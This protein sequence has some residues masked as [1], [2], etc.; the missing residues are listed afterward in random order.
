MLSEV[1]SWARELG[2]LVTTVVADGVLVH[3]EGYLGR[4][5]DAVHSEAMNAHCGIAARLRWNVII[6]HLGR[7]HGLVD[8][9]HQVL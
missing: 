2:G 7:G 3:L 8:L 9:H 6:N 1:V 4:N 5:L